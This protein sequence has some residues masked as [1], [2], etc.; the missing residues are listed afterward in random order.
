MIDLSNIRFIGQFVEESDSLSEKLRTSQ[1][2]GRYDHLEM[3]E[4]SCVWKGIG[5]GR[6]SV[7]GMGENLF[8][9]SYVVT[10]INNIGYVDE[11]KCYKL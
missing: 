2:H 1:N 3:G 6:D 9:C 7:L 11:Q 10:Y 5:L 4:V 8:D